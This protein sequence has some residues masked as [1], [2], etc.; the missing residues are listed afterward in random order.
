MKYLM[1]FLSKFDHV[2][3][4]DIEMIAN[5]PFGTLD[6]YLSSNMNYT[7]TKDLCVSTPQA[8]CNHS[9]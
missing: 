1:L 7:Q 8:Q 4:S 2:K 5:Q 3:D 6:Y 9:L